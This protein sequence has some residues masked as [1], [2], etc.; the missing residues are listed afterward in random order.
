MTRM[1]PR[2]ALYYICLEMGPV[3]KTNRD[4]NVTHRE[5]KLRDA[6]RTLQNFIDYRD[7]SG[8]SLQDLELEDFRHHSHEHQLHF[9]LGDTE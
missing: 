5:A 6:I 2:Q 8:D 3:A 1:T 9:D 7:P 4:D